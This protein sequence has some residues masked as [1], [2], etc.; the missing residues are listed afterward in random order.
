MNNETYEQQLESLRESR[1]LDP[2]QTRL[3]ALI[4]SMYEAINDLQQEVKSLRNELITTPVI[5]IK[6]KG[7]NEQKPSN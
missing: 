6:L 5:P 4:L 2:Y 3:R 7:N 1:F